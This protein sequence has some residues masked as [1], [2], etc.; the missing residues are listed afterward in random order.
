MESSFSLEGTKSMIPR[1]MLPGSLEAALKTAL[2]L[3][4]VEKMQNRSKI[5]A[6]RDH[7]PTLSTW[8]CSRACKFGFTNKGR[9]SGPRA[10][11]SDQ[12]FTHIDETLGEYSSPSLVNDPRR[13][14]SGNSD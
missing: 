14:I 6:H 1:F 13:K 10:R 9:L 11:N 5:R 4:L 7:E 8:N 2:G 3:L 12:M